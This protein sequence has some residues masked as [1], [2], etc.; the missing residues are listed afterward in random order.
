L[1]VVYLFHSA[2]SLQAFTKVWEELSE[3]YKFR[4]GGY[5]RVMQIGRRQG[6]N[7]A[8]AVI[9]FIDREGEIR[10]PRPAQGVQIGQTK[11]MRDVLG[12]DPR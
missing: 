7:A 10:T 11:L 3:R 12:L 2:L 8:M 4:N 6:D 1:F 5:T 9:E